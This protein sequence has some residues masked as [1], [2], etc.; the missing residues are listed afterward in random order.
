MISDHSP[1][2]QKTKPIRKGQKKTDTM[3]KADRDIVAVEKA[4]RGTKI[5]PSE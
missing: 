3:S 4:G 2:E 5:A 1:A